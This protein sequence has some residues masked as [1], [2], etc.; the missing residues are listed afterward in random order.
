MKFSKANN[1]LKTKLMNFQVHCVE[2]SLQF[3]FHIFL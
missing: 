2:M 3:Y 1:N